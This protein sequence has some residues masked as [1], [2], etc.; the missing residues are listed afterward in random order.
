MIVK[1]GLK[2]VVVGVNLMDLKWGID[3]V[4]EVIV[5]DFEK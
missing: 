3:K 1:E 5:K 4:V 2:N